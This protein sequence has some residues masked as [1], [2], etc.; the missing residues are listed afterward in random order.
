MSKPY[1][2]VMSSRCGAYKELEMVHEFLFGRDDNIKPFL[3]LKYQH[4]LNNEYFRMNKNEFNDLMMFL[5]EDPDYHWGSKL[6]SIEDIYK[7]MAADEKEVLDLFCEM[8]AC[9]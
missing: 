4:I 2:D 7:Q 1:K 5:T 3:Y 9:D 8:R 6:Q